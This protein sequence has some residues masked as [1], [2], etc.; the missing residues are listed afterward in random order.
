MLERAVDAVA[1]ETPLDPR[2]RRKALEIVDGVPAKNA[3]GRA[4]KLYR[5]VLASV[6]E[7]R[8][9]DGRRVVLGKAGSLEAAFSYMAR[10]LGI[11]IQP[12]VV[13]NRLA[14]PPVGPMTE[15]ENWDSVV[16]R[17]RTDRGDRWLTV[18]DKF[19]PF[20]YLPAE[21]RGQPAIILAEGL[22][23]EKTASQGA[24][25]GLTVEGKA[26][27]RED[28]SATV[29]LVQ[30]YTG[31]M[32]ISLRGVFDR[33]PESQVKDFVE[34]RILGRNFPG[35]RL[36]QLDIENKTALDQPLT[37]RMRAE[38][39]QLVKVAGGQGTLKAFFPMH[40]G[41]LATLP[42]RQ[43]PLLLGG[44]SHL[45]VNF[46]IELAE[47]FRAPTRLPQGEARD[48]ERVV[49]VKDTVSGRT[50]QLRRFVDVPADRVQPGKAYAAFATFAQDGDALVERDIV[51]A[52]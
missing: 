5:W 16:L 36:R 23:K 40:L 3:D 43:T 11:P 52:K 35:A 6:Q 19:A 13:K 2:L 20:G 42:E 47:G 32:G 45:E 18:R 39:P 50:L 14:P 30:R 8:E 17:L 24:A 51:L 9:G 26:Q 22:P 46:D 27:L 12:A 33:V 49:R 10:L 44:S 28:G 7:G 21:L 4:E 31:K 34:S 15:V 48:G 41:Q 37:L 1:D 25:D 29:D 38:V